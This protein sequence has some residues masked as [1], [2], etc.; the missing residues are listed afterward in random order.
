MRRLANFASG[1]DTPYHSNRQAIDVHNERVR[2]H[3]K[4]DD[5]GR[6]MERKDYDDP[7]WLPVVVEEIGEVARVICDWRHNPIYTN[8]E[9][10]REELIQVM[11]MCSAW[12]DAIDMDYDPDST[13]PSPT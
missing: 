8:Q 3:L 9:R 2:A 11:A 6:S 13:L 12:V 5:N 1:I 4:H 10:L 7:A